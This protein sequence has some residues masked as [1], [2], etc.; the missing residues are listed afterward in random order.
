MLHIGRNVCE[1]NPCMPGTCS[2]EEDAINCDCSDTYY[3]GERC[4]LGYAVA[5]PVPP[6]VKGSSEEV[7]LTSKPLIQTIVSITANDNS[8]LGINKQMISLSPQSSSGSYT[9]QANKSGLYRVSYD[10]IPGSLYIKPDDTIILVTERSRGEEPDYF[11]SQGLQSGHLGVGCCSKQLTL[12]LEQCFSN[13]TLHSYCQWNQTESSTDGVVHLSIASLYLPVSI[14]G[15]KVLNSLP[16]FLDTHY[17]THQ[18]LTC[19]KA[20]NQHCH[21]PSL[22]MDYNSNII[23][24]MLQYK[25]LSVSLFSSI[26][27][28]LPSW[29]KIEVHSLASSSYSVYDFMTFIG[30]AEEVKRLPGCD[31]IE[32][33][34]TSAL[35]YTHRTTSL[36]Q[37]TINSHPAFYHAQPVSPLCTIIDVCSGL[38]PTLKLAIP[39]SLVSKNNAASIRPLNIF[40]AGNAQVNF[41]SISLQ[42][43]GIIAPELQ[44]QL[45]YWNGKHRFR[46]TLPTHYQYKLNINFQKTFTGQNLE[47]DVKF[48]GSVYYQP[49][50]TIKEVPGLLVGKISL[51]VTTITN[52]KSVNLM[53]T[54]DEYPAI[55][56]Y[57]IEGASYENLPVGL[58]AILKYNE[59]LTDSFYRDHFSIPQ[60]VVDC[61]ILAFLSFD[62]SLN[63]NNVSFT[64]DCFTLSIG[65][66]H[67]QEGLRHNI[68]LPGSTTQDP[69]V[70][71]I[72]T[73]YRLSDSPYKFGR[74]S[75]LNTNNGPVLKV[76]YSSS[77][78]KLRGTLYSVNI[79]LLN[80]HSISNISIAN[81]QMTFQAQAKVFMNYDTRIIGSLATNNSVNIELN[82]EFVGT[83]RSDVSSYISQHLQNE[84]N[85]VIKRSNSAIDSVEISEEWRD[86]LYLQLTDNNDKLLQEEKQ[87]KEDNKS[88][89]E[90][91]ANTNDALNNLTI[92]LESYRVNN[93][94]LSVNELLCNNND[95]CNNECNS[96]L[97]CQTHNNSITFS[98][99][100]SCSEYEP[101]SH[102]IRQVKVVLV[103]DWQEQIQCQSCWETQWHKFLYISQTQC[104]NKI[105]VRVL[106]MSRY[107]IQY[108]NSTANESKLRPCIVNNN[109]QLYDALNCR[110]EISCYHEITNASCF[111][112]LAGCLQELGESFATINSTIS[113]LYSTYLN[114]LLKEEEMKLIIARKYAK[115]YRLRENTEFLESLFHTANQSYHTNVKANETLFEETDALIPF[116]SSFD[117]QPVTEIDILEVTNI[118][119]QFMLT[120]YTPAILPIEISYSILDTGEE[121][122]FIEMV[123]FL[124]PRELI[125][126]QLSGSVLES[127]VLLVRGTRR[128]KR[129]N[130]E[131]MA[132][133]FSSSIKFH[134]TCLQ[135]KGSNLYI[136]QILELLGQSFAKLNS[137]LSLINATTMKPYTNESHNG[138]SPIIAT[139]YNLIKADVSKQSHS[140]IELLKNNSF[141]SWQAQI[142]AIHSSIGPL[143]LFGCSSYL[144]CIGSIT[145][146]LEDILE[147][148]ADA[149]Q[150]L[151]QLRQIKDIILQVA[152]NKSLSYNEAYDALKKLLTVTE[153]NIVIDQWCTEP[154]I[155][156]THPPSSV[157]IEINSTTELSCTASSSLL[158]YWVKDNI[159]IPGSNSNRLML[160]NVGLGDEGE[161]WCVAVNGA[162]SSASIP[163]LVNVIMKPI[164][165]L[166]LPSHAYVY[167]EDTRGF[168]LTCDA[169]GIPAPGW[170]WF[171]KENEAHNWTL[172]SNSNSNVLTFNN[173]SFD[174]EGWYHCLALN[175]A[176]N[177]TSTPVFLNVLSAVTPTIQYEFVLMLSG[178]SEE[179]V[180]PIVDLLVSETN[181]SGLV[182]AGSPIVF[183]GN[184]TSI[185]FI[186]QSDNTILLE[187]MESTNNELDELAIQMMSSASQLEQDKEALLLLL[188]RT[189]QLTFTLEDSTQS[190]SLID[191]TVGPRTFTC[192]KEYQL[193]S[194]HLTCVACRPGSYG[195]VYMRSF[196]ESETVG[197]YIEELVPQC[198]ECPVGT[199]QENEGQSDC[200]SCPANYSTSRTGSVSVSDCKELCSPHHFSPTGLGPCSPC[201]PLTYQQYIGQRKCFPCG[202]DTMFDACVIPVSTTSIIKASNTVPTSNTNI[203]PSESSSRY[204]TTEHPPRSTVIKNSTTTISSK[205]PVPSAVGVEGKSNQFSTGAI[206]GIIV[207]LVTV[208]ILIIILIVA[209]VITRRKKATLRQQETSINQPSYEVELKFND[210]GSHNPKNLEAESDDLKLKQ[211]E[212]A[213]SL[214][215]DESHIYEE[216]PPP[217]EE[218][219]TEETIK[220]LLRPP[221]PPPNNPYSSIYDND[222]DIMEKK[223]LKV[224]DFYSSSDK[225]Y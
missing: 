59:Q 48:K 49:N 117:S 47:A 103:E 69:S 153:S 115:V 200:V 110:E 89:I 122:S 166:T 13:L 114:A 194:D 105:K 135:I 54:S 134:D 8:S 97:S 92:A 38:A 128:Q 78:N 195:Q 129:D 6:L 215:I 52:Q 64:T 172:I 45:V 158:Y 216:L 41:Q 207:A 187:G 77:T 5:Q 111:T 148:T 150:E 132:S 31:K 220:E 9:V 205:S 175:P 73:S 225:E 72:V 96:R 27:N 161:Y 212:G 164:F 104:C 120:N 124:Q 37:V 171:Y 176:G 43:D 186:L 189:N 160:T 140:M 157:S 130:H 116:V 79:S 14:A 177:V 101:A 118:S 214:H 57:P 222:D 10:A 33:A 94:T 36:L 3:T 102:I 66:L 86:E 30:T 142:E 180:Q 213:A 28:F 152:Y 217:I 15:V 83:F 108:I 193:D 209:I 123:N 76:M 17:S 87:L 224:A 58:S 192:Y 91:K 162:G 198:L 11:T 95:A 107:K 184:I 1:P 138:I 53:L 178:A 154:P 68:L 182:T 75:F 147:D 67:F 173:I 23:Q 206:I 21:T 74:F 40:I 22:I 127:Y 170:M 44:E 16:L 221:L 24:T 208:A 202:N 19:D 167:E 100:G 133:T 174:D 62:E 165:N 179:W 65:S 34:D 185:S 168:Q 143:E 183:S 2:V 197:E 93:D 112:D 80:S 71:L 149:V 139:Q 106:D 99:P 42:E 119:F 18:C 113:Q 199:Y 51:N 146:Q 70:S 155:I 98:V 131:A 109:T 63:I 159:T 188:Q 210:Y 84:L 144:D 151:S 81:N 191:Y 145:N 29:L 61:Q 219:I 204:Y 136:K 201:P 163:S 181:I 126:R 203:G 7:T 85:D 169:Y 25:S 35:I 211:D 190:V 223:S 56:T 218:E 82:G 4:Q 26:K 137:T 196:V 156:T 88:L 12:S 90:L 141:A 60:S 50:A 125:L 20:P 39:P 46:P 32:L 55:F 121:H